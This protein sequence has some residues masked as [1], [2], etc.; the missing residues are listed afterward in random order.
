[1]W[2][3]KNVDKVLLVENSYKKTWVA[4]TE[5]GQENAN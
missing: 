2:Q 5:Y 3:D 4:W 1:M